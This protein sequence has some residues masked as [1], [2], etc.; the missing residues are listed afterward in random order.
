MVRGAACLDKGLAA[1]GGAH[2]LRNALCVPEAQSPSILQVSLQY[3]VALQ[4]GLHVWAHPQ[5][6]AC[7]MALCLTCAAMC[8]ARPHVEALWF[9]LGWAWSA[10]CL[11]RP[12]AVA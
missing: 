2:C 7:W 3:L 5:T 1:A 4:D 11:V 8:Q 12:L 6:A 10:E 9:A